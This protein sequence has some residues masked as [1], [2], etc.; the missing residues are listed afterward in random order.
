MIVIDYKENI[1]LG[2]GPVELSKNFFHKSQRTIFN[3]T[4]YYNILDD[5]GNIIK[6]RSILILYLRN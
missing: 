5:N 3:G 1:K 6:K 2:G 4:I